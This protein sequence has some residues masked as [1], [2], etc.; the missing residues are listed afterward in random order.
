MARQRNVAVNALLATISVDGNDLHALDSCPQV[1]KC[2]VRADLE[3]RH[4]FR[5]PPSRHAAS[6]LQT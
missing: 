2:R 4:S 6:S 5:H 1:P 3:Q